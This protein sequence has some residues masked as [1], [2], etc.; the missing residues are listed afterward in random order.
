MPPPLDLSQLELCTPALRLLP[1]QHRLAEQILAYHLRNRDFLAPWSPRLRP[2]FFTLAA[3]AQK[4]QS[5][6][7]QI[8]KRTLLKFWLQ[9]HA[10]QDQLIGHVALSNIVWGGFRSGFLGYSIDQRH[11]R[12]GHARAAVAALV[13][14]AF[15][16]LK[17]HRIEANIMP[18]NLASIQ[19]VSPLGFEY[20]GLSPKYLKINGVWEDHAHY[21]LRNLAL[22]ESL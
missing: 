18:H 7:E 9:A 11:L 15:N 10:A 20:E 17:L 5:E 4:I 22:E 14:F 3:Q 1:P 6:R 8:Q 12:Q 2:H 21:V 13:T 16:T 19:V